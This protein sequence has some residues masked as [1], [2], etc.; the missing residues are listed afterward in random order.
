M[1]RRLDR[2][3]RMTYSTLS[4]YTLQTKDKLRINRQH[5]ESLT[6]PGSKVTF[7][8]DQPIPKP[9]PNLKV[10]FFDVDNCL[11]KKSLRI[12]DLME[13]SIHQYFQMKFNLDNETAR[14]LRENYYRTYGL[15]IKGLV[16]HHEIDA[17]EYNELVDDSLPLQDILK[18]DPEQR[19][20]LQRIRESG[21]FDKMWLFT[22][23]YKNHGLRCVRLLGIA[24]LFD[25]IT[26]CDYSQSDLV[27]KPDVRAF[28]KAKLQSGLGEYSNAYFIDDSGS[29]IR[30][31]IKLGLR[32]SIHLVE[33]GFDDFFSTSPSEA[34]IIKAITDLP[35]ACPEIFA[36]E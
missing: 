13:Q 31:S 12:H 9:D 29:N 14:E 34:T 24:D 28:E 22:N 35:K 15:A 10:F 20:I 1:Q 3:F 32:K 33:A 11:Y 7:D 21:C 17:V 4:E 5:L 23:A 6:Y 25:G 8:P 18:P 19:K 2:V 36:K 27:C 26:Y 16:D 30:T